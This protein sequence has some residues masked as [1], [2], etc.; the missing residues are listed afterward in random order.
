MKSQTELNLP[1]PA[2]LEAWHLVILLNRSTFKR[3][4]TWYI[5]C[6]IFSKE[7]SALKK[8]VN[9]FFTHEALESS[10][11]L[12]ETCPCVPDRIGIWKCWCLRRG[13]NRST[14]RKTSRSKGENQ[15]QTQPIYGVDAGIWTRATLVRGE[16]SH[17][18][19]ILAPHR[20]SPLQQTVATQ[21]AG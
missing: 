15:L 6:W 8:I 1:K 12:V 14:R 10:Y 13:E 19:A 16:R 7:T 18:C 9:C 11:E 20:T 4:R 5:S 2:K 17:H 3:R 21:A